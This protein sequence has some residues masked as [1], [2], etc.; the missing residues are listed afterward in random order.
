MLSYYFLKLILD[1][2]WLIY[3]LD[4]NGIIVYHVDKQR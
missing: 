2:F 4:W 1:Y 3:H